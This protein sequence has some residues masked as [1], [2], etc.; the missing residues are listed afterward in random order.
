MG[1]DMDADRLNRWLT[2]VANVAVVAGIVFLGLELRQNNQLLQFEAESIYFQNRVWGMER[3]I[4]NPEF[5]IL[6]FRARNGDEL[7]EF[8]AYQVRSY[9]RRIFLGLNWEFNQEKAGRLDIRSKKRWGEIIR[10]NRY[11]IS[12]WKWATENILTADFIRLMNSESQ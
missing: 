2:L 10:E 7:N 6:V 3:S 4:E 11:A 8:E 12:E 9:Y 5:G 1:T